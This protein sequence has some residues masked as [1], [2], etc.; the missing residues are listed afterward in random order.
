[1]MMMSECPVKTDRSTD[2]LYQAAVGGAAELRPGLSV[3]Y[4]TVVSTDTDRLALSSDLA[5]N[6]SWSWSFDVGLFV[7]FLA[8]VTEIPLE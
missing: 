2:Y 4:F 5:Q 1:M 7:C 3:V 6:W 8:V